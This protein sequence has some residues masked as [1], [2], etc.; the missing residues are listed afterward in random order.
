MSRHAV[1]IVALGRDVASDTVERGVRSPTVALLPWGDVFVDFLDRLGVSFDELREEF[2]GSWMFGYAAALATAGVR[3]RRRVSDVAR[4]RAGV[5]AARADGRGA[6]SAA[7]L[8]CVRG[9]SRAPARRPPRRPSR[10]PLARPGRGDPRRAVPGNAAASTARAAARREAATRSSARSTRTRA[11]TS[12]SPSGRRAGVPVYGTFQGADYR[13][14]RLERPVRPRSIRARC[15]ADRRCAPRARARP[16]DV[17]RPGDKLAH[18]AEPD[19]RERLERAS[20]DPTCESG[21]RDPGGRARRR[22]ARTGADPRARASTS[23]STRGRRSVRRNADAASPI[24][25]GATA[26]TRR[27]RR[28]RRARRTGVHVVD[29]WVEDRAA[30]RALLSAADLYAFPSRHEGLPVVAAR[31]D[32]VRLAGRRCRCDRGGGRRRRHRVV[33][34]RDDAG[35]LA[36]AIGALLDDSSA[37]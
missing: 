37:R 14:S 35:A 34:P 20:T 6:P 11:S 36:D 24:L 30:L 1:Y 32:G 25:V 29:E 3:T 33:V 21:A 4:R 13:V 19:R 23:C 17:R 15:R 22:L 7:D 8:A 9:A 28:A 10:S 27:A 5:G 18:V 31:G 2:V 12:A 16:A 26:R